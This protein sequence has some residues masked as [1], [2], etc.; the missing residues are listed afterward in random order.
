VETHRWGRVVVIG[1]SIA[2]LLAARALAD[3]AGRVTIIDRDRI[4]DEP[5]H[6][7]GVPHGRHIHVV[8][9]AGQR[10][11]EVLLPGV[12][13]ELAALDVPA[14]GMPR[15]IIQRNRG[16][17][18]RR[19]PESLTFLTGTRALVEHVV[20]RRVLAHDKVDA[21]DSLEV[22]G[23]DGDR[24]R[25]RGVRLR[26]RG[27]DQDEQ[28]MAADLVVDASGRGSRTAQWLTSIGARPPV[29]ERIQTGL[30]YATRRYRAVVD[31]AVAE[32]LGIYLL[33]RPGAGSGA[34]VMPIEEKGSYL[35]TLT[36]LPGDEPP[37]DPEAF[38]AFTARLEHPIVHEWLAAAQP[39]GPPLGYRST[40][41]IRRRYDRLS[42]PDGLLVVGDAATS[43]NPVYGQG[44]SVAALGTQAL[45]RALA[46]GQPPIRR[47]QR[48]VIDAG[49]QAWRISTGV[50][51]NLPTATGNALRSGPVDR[52]ASWYL[53]RVQDHA[54]SDMVVGNAF[55][56]V[57]HLVAPI[58]SLL[59]G[60]VART[61]LFGRPRPGP[62]EPPMRP[63]S[64]D[65][66]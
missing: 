33:P 9:T 26:P 44:I 50:D 1:N 4:P 22:I 32:Y 53:G 58:A 41:N 56:D 14:V 6:R 57:V 42:G 34:V 27:A 39:D 38:E 7:A 23:L 19:W 3:H 47:L 64:G 61:V 25:V 15:D 51:K 49:D 52:A 43:F 54:A 45:A 63:E 31:P 46:T 37:T 12:L 10:A 2:G 48:L 11:M 60:R 36:G 28:T 55:R 65:T 18:V 30:A 24:H 21:L 40:A 5:Q 16:Q 59:R 35:V 29:E 8:L 13:D 20:R 17:W 66:R 62:A